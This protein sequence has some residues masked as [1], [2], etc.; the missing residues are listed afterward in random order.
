[1][2]TNTEEPLTVSLISKVKVLETVYSDIHTICNKIALL[3]PSDSLF[4]TK[5]AQLKDNLKTLPKPDLPQEDSAQETITK[6]V[7]TTQEELK[8][9]IHDPSIQDSIYSI[10]EKRFSDMIDYL[11]GKTFEKC[12]KHKP[13]LGSI[14]KIVKNTEKKLAVF[15]KE[16]RKLSADRKTGLRDITPVRTNV[17]RSISPADK[18]NYSITQENNDLKDLVKK[19]QMERDV[20]KA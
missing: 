11:L 12:F 13:N 19:L 5:F 18:K 20:L 6:I 16:A 8:S 14:E 7:F 17:H 4:S 2:K 15:Q 1:M 9:L 10:I 3:K